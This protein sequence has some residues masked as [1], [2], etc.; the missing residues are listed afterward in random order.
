MPE[1]R[2][3]RLERTHRNDYARQLRQNV[4]K[5]RGHEDLLDRLLVSA[6]IE[7]RS[8]ERFEVL[9][10]Y[11]E[12]PDPVLSP[13]HVIVRPHFSLISSGTE[14]ASIHRGGAV[15]AVAENPSYIGKI[16][17]VMKNEGPL[18]TTREVLAKFSEYAVLGYSGAGIVIEKHANVRDIEIGDRVAYGGEG[19]GHAESILVG[20][21]LVDFADS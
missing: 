14:T 4:R 8:C 1:L 7:L 3:G 6:L 9:A 2:G 5:G 16:L 21:N 12:V 10:R 15:G 13:H 19:T 17:D 20:Q 18:R 11:C